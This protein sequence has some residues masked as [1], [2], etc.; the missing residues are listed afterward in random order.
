MANQSIASSWEEWEHDAHLELQECMCHPI[1]FH[2]KI[3][4]DIMH[5]QQAIYQPDAL[6]LIN[7]MIKEI[8]AHFEKKHW[9]LIKHSTTLLQ[10]NHQV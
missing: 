1:A 7:D 3:M 10:C 9:V 5:M 2:A 6:Q 8:N 4:G